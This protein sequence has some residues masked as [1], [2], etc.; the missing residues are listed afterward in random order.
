MRHSVTFQ[1][2]NQDGSVYLS[3]TYLDD[4]GMVTGNSDTY[5]RITGMINADYY[6]KPWLQITTNNQIRIL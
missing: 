2:G 3:L 4:N 6:I 1:K 5:E